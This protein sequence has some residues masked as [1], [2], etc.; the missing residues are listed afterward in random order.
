MKSK[1]L[2]ISLAVV[3]ALSIGLAGCDTNGNGGP[4]PADTIVLVASVSTDGPLADVHN[5]AK[6]PILDAYLADSPTITIGSTTYP[7]AKKY[8][9]DGSSMATMQENTD[10]MIDEIGAGTAHFLLGP[11]CTAFLEAQATKCTTAK[12]VQMGMEGGATSLFP[13]LSVYGYSFFNLSFSNWFEIPVLAKILAEA[14]EDAHPGDT[15]VAVIGYQFDSHGDEYL[16][17]AQ[18]YF[19]K[20]DI[21]ICDTHAMVP[22][23]GGACADL[24]A[25][26]KTCDADILCL[27]AYPEFVFGIHAA[28][29]A[30]TLW[31]PEAV[32]LGPGACFGVYRDDTYG[33]GAAAEGA[34]T[35]VTGNNATSPAMAELFNEKLTCP[36]SPPAPPGMGSPYNIFCQDFWGHPCYWTALDFV[37][38]AAAAEGSN[39][40]GAGFT[41]D[42]TVYRDYLRSA[43]VESVFGDSYY[44][45]PTHALNATQYSW[46][47]SDL[48]DP[49]PEG[50]AGLLSYKLHHGEIGQWQDGYMEVIGYDGIGGGG[51]EY[52]LTSYCVT[53]PYWYAPMW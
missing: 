39:N 45:T 49:V 52:E 11:S 31:Q 19:A 25:K 38:A 17:E 23:D 27:F 36:P 35:F 32:V 37:Y 5:N 42:Q 22:N 14:H 2:F 15:P 4:E 48:V 33:A 10:A 12:V 18:K 44:C 47:S 40:D 3:L 9:P 26:A 6:A 41:I 29:I 7:V 1:I 21:D 53:A 34:M 16:A 20:E 13:F 46:A 8:Y 30:E 51:D 28:A 50:S 43:H 24:V